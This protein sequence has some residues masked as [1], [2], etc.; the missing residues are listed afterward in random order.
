PPPPKVSPGTF[1]PI[2]SAGIF[3]ILSFFNLEESRVSASAG[4]PAFYFVGGH[5]AHTFTVLE[6]V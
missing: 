1:L 3:T 4:I 2:L 5:K 6:V